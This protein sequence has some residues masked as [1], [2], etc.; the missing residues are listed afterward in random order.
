MLIQRRQYV[1]MLIKLG[2]LRNSGL[3]PNPV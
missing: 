2:L 1:A 3:T